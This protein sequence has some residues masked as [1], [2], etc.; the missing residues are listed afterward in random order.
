LGLRP[1]HPDLQP[2]IDAL[3][4][5]R[6]IDLVD[7]QVQRAIDFGSNMLGEIDEEFFDDDEVVAFSDD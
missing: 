6:T 3:I 5:D 4:A 7:D 1:Y 2:A